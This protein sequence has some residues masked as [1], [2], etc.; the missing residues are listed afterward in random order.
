MATPVGKLDEEDLL[1]AAAVL[2]I[3]WLQTQTESSTLDA[4]LIKA[5]KLAQGELLKGDGV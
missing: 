3:M 4:F 5:G 2:V 1:L